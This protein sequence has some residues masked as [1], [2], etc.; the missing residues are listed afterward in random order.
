M[1]CELP[2]LLYGDTSTHRDKPHE[3]PGTMNAEEDEKLY[4]EQQ[5]AKSDHTTLAHW[6]LAP[7]SRPGGSEGQFFGQVGGAHFVSRCDETKWGTFR[8]DFCR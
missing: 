3:A 2:L 6:Q 5:T 4:S 8:P 1:C 7:A